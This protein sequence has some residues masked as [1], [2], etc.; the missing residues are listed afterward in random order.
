MGKKG[1]EKKGQVAVFVI[2]AVVIVAAVGLYFLFRSITNQSQFS[3]TFNP[4]ESQILNCISQDLDGRF[5]K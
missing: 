1:W 2:I 4:V 5:I 3:P